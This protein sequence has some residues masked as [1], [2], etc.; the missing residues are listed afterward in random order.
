MN[1]KKVLELS[2]TVGER[3]IFNGCA[4][5]Q[6]EEQVHKV[7]SV[8]PFTNKEV[9]VSTSSIIVTVDSP[10]SGLL[11][12]VKHVEKK[13]MNQERI[14]LIEDIVIAFASGNTT[15]EAA[16]VEL[17]NLAQKSTY[18]FPVI[19]S[20]FA[21][22]GAFRA[23]MFGGTVYDFLAAIVVGTCVG[24]TLQYLNTQKLPSFLV[25][26]SAGFIVGFVAV[27]L[28]NFHIGTNLDKIIVG[29]LITFAPG[30]PMAHA[31]NDVLNGEQLSGW[32][33]VMEAILSG[34][35]IAV[36]IAFALYFWA[37]IGGVN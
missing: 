37:F 15:A 25:T 29:S 27:L 6:I 35:A 1:S 32:I 16:I 21:L 24:I 31:V 5:H 7:L 11:T 20:A 22:S 28:R 23:F 14:A 34:V 2:V 36:G 3:L 9:F 30:V 12:M 10:E 17:R 18:T 33:R 4:T 8:C 19:V 26:M 13:G